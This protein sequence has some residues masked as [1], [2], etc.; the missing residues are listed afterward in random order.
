M[1]PKLEAVRYP[2]GKP[3]VRSK[4]TPTEA[5]LQAFIAYLLADRLENYGYDWKDFRRLS[6]QRARARL[7]LRQVTGHFAGHCW[8]DSLA[9][10][11]CS[12]RLMLESHN[13]RPCAITYI[14]GQSGNEELTNLMRRL[15]NPKAGWVS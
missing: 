5:Q 14:V 11:Q 4:R 6:N 12:S 9:W 15:V 1:K 10:E 3:S 7:A 13:G 2:K 8:V